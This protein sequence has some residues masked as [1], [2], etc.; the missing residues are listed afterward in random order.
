MIVVSCLPMC[1]N[2]CHESV[3]VNIMST[4]FGSGKHV[5][6]L[7]ANA[8]IRISICNI[9]ASLHSRSFVCCSGHANPLGISHAMRKQWFKLSVMS[10]T[11]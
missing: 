5:K 6:H 11:L 9:G 8:S 10:G 1:V 3:H 4:A 2:Y 7:L